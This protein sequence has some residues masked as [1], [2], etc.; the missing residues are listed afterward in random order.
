VATRAGL[1]CVTRGRRSTVLSVAASL[2]V[3]ASLS[4]ALFAQAASARTTAAKNTPVKVVKQEMRSGFGEIL[5]NKESHALY[6][7]T[8]PPCT[9]GCLTVWP[10][11]LMPKG[12]TKPAGA[13][14]LGT[15]SFG[16]GRLQVTYHKRP[17]Y[18]FYQD[19]KKSVNGNGVSGFDVATV[20]S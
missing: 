17:L 8:M 16:S 5:T 6:I 18:T 20:A 19:D 10:P 14:G 7:D 4:G 1:T 2:V 15:T 3:A 9:G 13:R 12:K 11:L